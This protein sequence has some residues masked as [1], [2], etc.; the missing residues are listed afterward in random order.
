MAEIR[1]AVRRLSLIS[2]MK[3]LF[4]V[5]SAL[6]VLPAAHAA[7]VYDVGPAFPKTMLKDVS[8][9]T[10]QPGDVVNIHTKPGGYHEKIQISQ[11]GTSTQHIVIHG[12]PD[13]VT[14]AL[15]IIDANQAIEDPNVQYRPGISNTFGLITVSPRQTGYVYGGS[16]IAFV[17]IENLDIRNALYTSD[18]SISFTDQF[19]V[20]HPYNTFACGIYI[21]WARDFTVRGC[22][23][24][25]C[26]NGL[27]ANSKNGAAQSS[28]RLLIEGNYF[29]DNGLPSTPDPAHPGQVLSNGY[30]EHDCYI[31]SVGVTYQYNHFGPMRAGCHGDAI[32]DRSSSIVIRY[33]EFDLGEQGAAMLLLE[34]Q[35]G[36]GF[37]E[38]QPGYAD[39]YVYGNSITI[40]NYAS[41]VNMLSWI[42]QG[43]ASSYDTLHRGTLYF[44]NNT[45]VNHH[46]RLALFELTATT[47]TGTSPT[48]ENIDC[49]NNIFFTDT[50]FMNATYEKMIFSTPG[51]T[52][53]GGDI[54]L[55]GPNWIS[56]GWAKD[57]PGHAYGGA[58]NGITNLIVGDTFGAN[59]PNFVDANTRDYHVLTGSN[60]LDAGAPLAANAIALGH[61]DTLEYLASQGFQ[62]RTQN[63]GA[64]DL[65]SVESSGIPPPPPAGGMLQFSAAAYSVNENAGSIT[66]DVTRSGGSTGAVSVAYNVSGG[67]ATQGG[68]FTASNGVLNWPAGDL[69]PRSFTITLINDS[70][71]ENAESIQL[72]LSNVSGGAGYGVPSYAGITIN[73]DDIPPSQPIVAVTGSGKLI[74][75]TTGA[76][77]TIIS[78]VTVTGIDASQTLRGLAFRRSTGQL[79]VVGAV[80]GTGPVAASLYLLNPATGA[81]TKIADITSPQLAHPSF[82]LGIDPS[83]DQMHILG[84]TG[85]HLRLNPN[86]GAVL[87]VDTPLAFATGDTHFGATPGIVGADFTPGLAPTVY[88]IDKTIDSLVRVGS[89]GGLPLNSSSGQLTTIGALGTDTEGLTGLD[90]S[91]AGVGYAVLNPATGSSSNLYVIDPLSGHATSL[92]QIGVAEQVRD[93]VVAVPGDISFVSNAYSVS[94]S[95]S[96][97][98]IGIARTGGSWGAVSVDFSTSGGTASAGNDYTSVSQTVSWLDG[99]VGVKTLSIPIKSDTLVEGGE[100]VNLTLSNVTGG[101]LLLQPSVSILTINEP[102]YQNWKNLTFGI[103]ANNPLVSG[104]AACPAGDGVPN[105]LKYAAGLYPFSHAGAAR[106]AI[107]ISGSKLL[108]TFQHDPAATDATLVVDA[109]TDLVQWFAGS[110]YGQLGDIPSNAASTQLSRVMDP[111]TGLE[112]ITVQSNVTTPTTGFLRL[113]VSQP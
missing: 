13:P 28:A 60:I 77:G 70:T 75:F 41:P 109:T 1:H 21:E 62:T 99:E 19:G 25:N 110:Q 8:W 29:H 57:S 27:F 51:T 113:R 83:T 44:F 42:S 16:H 61:A 85:Q 82:D 4:A 33:N 36:A 104:D 108:L 30:H 89:V 79:Y 64:M 12:V 93:I 71:L 53:G 74:R 91:P 73:D 68:D 87:A 10:L 106:P 63:G 112:T 84:S 96:S 14:G 78:N 45:L 105:L 46:N 3:A 54:N 55:N 32:K 86:T 2:N 48:F 34:P 90:F 95:N 50:V 17:D 81:V 52:N 11:A 59:N 6:A 65:G 40:R 100:T 47:Y 22:E 18:G 67:T 5:L 92:G 49:R 35:G 7:T 23:I 58:L 24:N 69:T 72:A 101:A 111:A 66:I 31:E 37:I 43:P 15:P 102:P 26:D 80:G 107:S 76:P 94:E 9:A 88:A 20:T 39:A 97:A 103:H 38:F 98:A 56:P